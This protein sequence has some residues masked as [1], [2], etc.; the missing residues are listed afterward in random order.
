MNPPG[1]DALDGFRDTG[2][3][4]K[5]GRSV[6]VSTTTL[7]AEW[8]SRGRPLVSLIKVDVEGAEPLVFAGAMEVIRRCRPVIVSEW[9]LANLAAY[10]TPFSQILEF[11][12]GIDY[13]AYMIPGL[14]V[15]D[16]VAFRFQLALA[17]NML[18]LPNP[19][20]SLKD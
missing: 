9:C 18:L 13:T 8:E 11:A 10:H 2:R 5:E 6:E 1:H 17:E 12:A 19:T 14:T 20:D 3:A 4:G 15:A 16:P 7:D